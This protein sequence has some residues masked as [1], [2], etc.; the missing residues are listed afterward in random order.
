MTRAFIVSASRRLAVAALA[1]LLGAQCQNPA[2]L[3]T[4]LTGVITRGP[5]MP[6]C[7]ENVPCDAPMQSTFEVRRGDKRVTSFTTDADGKFTVKLPPGTYAIVPTGGGLMGTQ[8]RE[9]N[10]GPEALTE[11]RL[12]FDTGIR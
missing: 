1:L 8:S 7:R 2:A 12:S 10:V 4:G 11:V 6:V 9:V 3:T 5:I